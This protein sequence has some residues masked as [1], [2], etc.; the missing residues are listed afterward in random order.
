M[1]DEWQ[2]QLSHA[3]TLGCQLTC[4]LS[5]KACFPDKV[6]DQLTCAHDPKPALPIATGN[7]GQGGEG[8][9]PSPTPLHDQ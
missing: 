2:G 8:I 5:T 9:I 3:L 1:S 6:Q 7:D 4:A